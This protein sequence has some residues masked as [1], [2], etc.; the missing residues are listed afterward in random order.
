V[1]TYQLGGHEAQIAIEAA[2]VRNPFGKQILQSFRCS[3]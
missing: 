1:L 3:P 2:S